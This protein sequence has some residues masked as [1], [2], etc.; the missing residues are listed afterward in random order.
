MKLLEENLGVIKQ[1]TVK[2]FTKLV[3]RSKKISVISEVADGLSVTVNIY[4]FQLIFNLYRR[5]DLE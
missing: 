5:M 1:E 2:H 4:F 3:E